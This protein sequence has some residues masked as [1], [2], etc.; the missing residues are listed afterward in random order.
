[1][2]M[3][4][5]CV[6]FGAQTSPRYDFVDLFVTGMVGWKGLSASAQDGVTEYIKIAGWP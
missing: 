1:M 6:P 4:L 5:V 3:V 2:S